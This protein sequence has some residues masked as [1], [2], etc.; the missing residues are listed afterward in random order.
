MS[1]TP[2]SSDRYQ[3]NHCGDYAP[4]HSFY[5]AA[6]CSESC[7]RAA[8]A[9]PILNTIT[10]DHTTCVTCFRQL[11]VIEEPPE[12]APSAAVGFQYRTENAAWGEKQRPT[13]S[14]DQDDDPDL[15]SLN[16]QVYAYEVKDKTSNEIRE[17]YP[18]RKFDRANEPE[19][20][21]GVNDPVKTGTICHVCG[22]TE[23]NVVDEDLRSNCST[24]LV[25]HHLTERV[26]DLDTSIDEQQFW[27]VYT[28]ADRSIQDALE[29]AVI[30]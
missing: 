11:K 23:H 4:A 8:D 28:E 1:V 21:S 16:Q 20:T 7:R 13:G 14:R 9:E 22:N 18:G 25:G 5:D 26:R 29:A 10:H 19:P 2:T 30:L 15:P 3:C 24:M 6:M 12:R 17:Y 27:D